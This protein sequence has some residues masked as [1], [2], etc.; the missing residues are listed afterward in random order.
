MSA[1]WSVRTVLLASKVISTSPVCLMIES[2]AR[3]TSTPI[4]TA[5]DGSVTVL[6]D[7]LGSAVDARSKAAT[8]RRVK[9]VSKYHTRKTTRREESDCFHLNLTSSLLFFSRLIA[10]VAS[11]SRES[12]ISTAT[13]NSSVI[14]ALLW[15]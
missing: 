1:R 3:F 5:T 11:V 8:Q 2:P 7:T 14:V 9:D 10:M 13:S 12:P 15:K 4:R 6:L